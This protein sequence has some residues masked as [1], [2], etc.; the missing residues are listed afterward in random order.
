MRA[1]YRGLPPGDV[2]ARGRVTLFERPLA[3]ANRFWERLKGAVEP[4]PIYS[5]SLDFHAH[6]SD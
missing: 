2:Q 4:P 5:S 6:T 1:V 3:G